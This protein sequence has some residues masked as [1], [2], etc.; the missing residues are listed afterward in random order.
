MVTSGE[1]VQGWAVWEAVREERIR[2]H[3]KHGD[4]SMEASAPNT[5][6]RLAILMEEVGEVAREFNEA[7]HGN[8]PVD[9]ALLRKELIQV[10]AMAG[11]WA[12][13]CVDFGGDDR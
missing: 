7:E 5:Y 4:T 2:A 8:R 1:D 9:L 10:A 12:D 11:A 13:A 3:Q 6:R